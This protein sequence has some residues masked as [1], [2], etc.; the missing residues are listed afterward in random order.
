MKKRV[1]YYVGVFL[2]NIFMCSCVTPINDFEQ[3]SYT[4]F[5]TIEASITDQPNTSKVRIYKSSDDLTNS[6]FKTVNQAKVYFLNEKG[7]KETLSESSISGTYLPSKSFIGKVGSTYTLFIETADGSKYQSTPETMKVS[8]EI[9]KIITNYELRDNF[10]RGDA[11]RGG[12]NVYVDFQ[13]PP[14]IGDNYQWVWTHY[15]RANT[16]SN[17]VFGSYNFRL[18]SCV[19]STPATN[20]TLNYRCNADCWNI[21]YAS[22]LN[23]LSDSYLNGQRITG[24]QVARIP[25][26]STSNY[27]LQLEQRAITRNAF[28]YYQDLKIQTQN[29]GTLFDIPAETRF[30][31]NIKSTTN[32]EEKILGIFDVYSVKKKII[33]IDRVK[34]IPNDETAVFVNIVEGKIVECSPLELSFGCQDKTPCVEGRFR[35]KIKPEGWKD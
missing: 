6:V 16:C 28:N 30:S 19:I 13:E 9:D 8:P 35:T 17:C 4:K 24:K 7:A 2:L 22:E 31:F 3:I 10:S 29:N 20:L 27:Y 33:Y 26:D 15:E 34:D 14:T 25:F 5:L 11:R 1:L 32:P 18:N 21:T 23:V 12:F